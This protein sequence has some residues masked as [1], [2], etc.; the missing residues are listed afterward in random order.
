MTG[1][2]A[3]GFL[4]KVFFVRDPNKPGYYIAQT[5]VDLMNMFSTEGK[6]TIIGTEKCKDEK[7]VSIQVNYH[8]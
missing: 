7:G 6:N 1:T 2:A 4:W 3:T 5:H 8:Y